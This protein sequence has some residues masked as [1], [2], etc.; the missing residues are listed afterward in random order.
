[1]FHLFFIDLGDKAVE[2]LDNLN[3]SLLA[4]A[5]ILKN[6]FSVEAVIKIDTD[7]LLSEGETL[8]DAAH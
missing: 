7:K 2:G 4:Q 1:M 6:F 3:Q 5:D 8:G